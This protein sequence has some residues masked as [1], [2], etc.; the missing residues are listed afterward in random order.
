[1][2][3]TGTRLIID[4]SGIKRPWS[5]TTFWILKR[6]PIPPIFVKLQ[7]S[8]MGQAKKIAL[9]MAHETGLT[10]INGYDHPH[11]M[12]GQGTIGLE[13]V[14]QVN[15][16]DAVVIPV[17]GGGLIAGIAT[18]IKNLSPQ[19]KIIVSRTFCVSFRIACKS[20]TQSLN[21]RL[22]H[23]STGCGVGKVSEFHK[24]TGKRSPNLH[25]EQGNAGRW[26]GGATSWVQCICHDR[27][28]A[29]QDDSGQRGVDCPGH[30]A[31]GRAGEVCR[32]GCRS[33]RIGRYPGRPHGRVQRQ[34]VAI[35]LVVIKLCQGN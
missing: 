8:D 23:I 15:S 28:P 31:P 18:A 33:F 12:S 10:Y 25:P 1:M 14:E 7:G 19:T 5:G 22:A 13:I 9:R 32:R 24:S 2:H 20:A 27:A 34:E 30:S 17:G 35:I 4:F 26:V 16:I 3:S 11:I 21:H 29:G 6:T